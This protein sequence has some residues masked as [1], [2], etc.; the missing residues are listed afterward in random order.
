MLKDFCPG[1][2][3]DDFNVSISLTIVCFLFFSLYI[4]K[5]VTTLYFLYIF[6]FAQ[7]HKLKWAKLYLTQTVSDI[8]HFPYPPEL[9]TLY[10]PLASHTISLHSWT[11]YTVEAYFSE[12]LNKI[13]R[14]FVVERQVSIFSSYI[15]VI[16][17]CISTR[18]WPSPMKFTISFIFL[19]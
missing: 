19:I 5:N 16:T 15:K 12:P 13:E 18:W 10:Y 9:C 7:V 14:A 17:S 3:C 4:L 8:S 1:R 11:L 2:K 6:Y